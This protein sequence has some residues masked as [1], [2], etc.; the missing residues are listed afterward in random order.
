MNFDFD[1]DI[2]R[3]AWHSVKWDRYRDRDVIPLW[4]ADMD[5]P[6]PDFLLET[7]HNRLQQHR[8]LGYSSI[9][10][11]LVESFVAWTD[12]MF[13][14]QVNE[15][16]LVWIP[17]VMT[18]I[19]IAIRVV[20]KRGDHCVIPVPVYPPFLWVP[21]QHDR[22]PSFSPLVRHQDSWKMDFDDVRS[23]TKNAS[24][25]L[26]CNPQ[27]PTGRV[28]T[29][30]ELI[31]LATVCIKHKTVLISDD[32]HWGLVLDEDLAYTPIASLD[33]EIAAQTI[34]LYSHTKT[35]NIPG[36]SVA[37]AVIP[38]PE[39]RRAFKSQAQRIHPSLSPLALAGATAAYR[40]E[41]T[42]LVELNSYLRQ[43]HDLLRQA[44]IDSQVLG[45]TAVEGTHL[46][47]ID[48]TRLPVSN[49]KKHFES[50][51]L[52]LS[53]G[54]EF[55]GPGFVRLNFAIPRTLLEISIERLRGATDLYQ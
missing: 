3:R 39:I 46:M 1:T 4:L 55:R 25:V 43:N 48:T 38:D 33:P 11:E 20:G 54:V 2:D 22:V 9:P 41:T 14:W 31:D 15:D 21:E 13:R 24:T 49:P 27:N 10:S 12:R 18:G 34:S 36:E 16:W 28:Y 37:V 42:W 6:T 40:D 29:R 44:V 52:G 30:Q 51:G 35:Y 45:T 5:F 19:N 32:I 26:F 7:I 17:S 50:F 47:W 23:T 8:I 53:D